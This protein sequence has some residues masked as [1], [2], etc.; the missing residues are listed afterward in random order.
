MLIAI[1]RTRTVGTGVNL[2]G[3]LGETEAAPEGLVGGKQW[4]YRESGL[5]R[6]LGPLPRK[7][8][9]FSLEMA[10]FGELRAV[11]EKIWETTCISVP[12]PNS[13]EHVTLSP[14]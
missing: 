11:F 14:P 3:I 10:R 8:G 6:K 1:L 13:G 9:I 7:K 5:D 12:T 4:V 2:A